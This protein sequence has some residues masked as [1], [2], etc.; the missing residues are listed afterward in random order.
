MRPS[1]CANVQAA[2]LGTVILFAGQTARGAS[3]LFDGFG[4]GDRDNDGAPDG[5]VENPADVGAA[6]YTARSSSSITASIASDA[7]IGS[8]NVPQ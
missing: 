1:V 5:P 2:L 7:T 8:G 6:F 3:L 4:D